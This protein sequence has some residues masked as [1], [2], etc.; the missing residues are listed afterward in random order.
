MP[1]FANSVNL[2]YDIQLIAEYTV[3]PHAGAWIETTLWQRTYKRSCKSH[4][5][6]VRGLKLADSEAVEA[7][8]VAPHAGA[9]IETVTGVEVVTEEEVAP[10]AGAWI[11][12]VLECNSN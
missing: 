3:A 9:W 10:H 4:P 11:E 8:K 12:T 1:L 2:H 7:I 5:M 6:R